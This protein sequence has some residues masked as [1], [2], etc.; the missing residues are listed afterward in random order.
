[1]YLTQHTDYG[2]RVLIYTAIND[3]A[4]VNIGTIADT[5]GISKSH[6]MK[7][8]T[9]L[10]K[11]GF[12]D[13]VRGKGGGLKLACSADQINIGAVVRH[14]EPM[15]MVECMGSNNDCLIAPNCRLAG[16]IGGGVKAF[17]NYLDG[18][19]LADLLNKPTYDLLYLPKIEIVSDFRL[20]AVR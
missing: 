5:Y 9:A 14:L 4:L 10:V 11:G 7:V 6:L 2:L 12:L 17:L 8:V 18:F 15:Q 19:T 16:I 20:G 3:D 13:S 1:M